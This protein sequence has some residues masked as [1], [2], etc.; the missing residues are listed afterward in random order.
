MSICDISVINFK[1]L[2]YSHD[3]SAANLANILELKSSASITNIENGKAAPSYELLE[4]YADTFAISVDWLM[5][6]SKA[7]YTE[8]SLLTA[9]EA[10]L[11]KLQKV[12][13][14]GKYSQF[15]KNYLD[16]E[17]RCKLFTAKA[18]GSIVFLMHSE[19][20]PLVASLLDSQQYN[21]TPK[22]I[23]DKLINNIVHRNVSSYYDSKLTK[24][25]REKLD[26]FA[27]LMHNDQSVKPYEIEEYIEEY[28]KQQ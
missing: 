28:L 8:D 18:R 14:S 25:S 13:S 9:E 26:L 12:D 4:R 3:I 24:K 21:A 27:K 15:E 20:I 1:A 23:I 16:S 7:I 6:R 10:I 22:S 19:Y 5:G 2:R 11:A 17:Q